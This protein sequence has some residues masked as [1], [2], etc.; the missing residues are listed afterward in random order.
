MTTP[1]IESLDKQAERLINTLDNLNRLEIESYFNHIRQEN[2]YDAQEILEADLEPDEA[3]I[4]VDYHK[5]Q[6]EKSFN[7]VL[8]TLDEVLAQYE[9]SFTKENNYK[10]L[11]I[12]FNYKG[13][14]H[15]GE[16]AP[17]SFNNKPIAWYG[18]EQVDLSNLRQIWLI[19]PID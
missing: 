13:Q 7:L 11:S 3:R 10:P 17:H 8:A 15:T 18:H 2:Y 16:I 9:K 6:S 19:S 12:V 4:V 5:R 14:L 1:E